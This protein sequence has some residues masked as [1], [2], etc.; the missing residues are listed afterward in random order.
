M[1]RPGNGSSMSSASATPPMTVMTITLPSSR[2][3][4]MTAVVNDGSVTKNS[5]LDKPAKPL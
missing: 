1:P 3:V 4:L 2:T 5:K